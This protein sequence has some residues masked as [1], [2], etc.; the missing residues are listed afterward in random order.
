MRKTLM[1]ILDH[2]TAARSGRLP[3]LLCLL[4]CLAATR[5]AFAQTG[6]LAPIQQQFDAYRKQALQEKLYLH[7]DRPFY[8]CGETMWFKAYTLD[9]TLH[10]PLDLSKVAYVEVL[11]DTRKPV[12]QAKIALKDGAGNGSFVLPTTLASGNYTVRA[13]TSWMKNFDPEFYFQEPVTIVNS[14]TGLG[15]APEQAPTAYAIQFFP[16]GGNL[17]QGIPGKVAFQAVNKKSGK[18]ADFTGRIVDGEG[19][20]VAQLRPLKFGIGNFTFTPTAGTTYTAIIEFADKRVLRQQLPQV[21]AQGYSLRLRE[22]DPNQLQIMVSGPQTGTVYLLGHARQMVGVAESAALQQ[23]TAT[24]TVDT[25]KLPEGINH[26]TV[27]DSQRQPVC[28]RLYFKRPTQK[29]LVEATTDKKQYATRQQVT[30][31]LLTQASPGTAIPANLSVAVY[32]LDSLQ[33]ASPTDIYTYLWLTSDLKGTIEQPSYYFTASGPVADEAL[34]NLMLTHGWSRFRWEDVLQAQQPAYPFAPEYD[35]HFIRGKVTDA[36][37]GV[38]VRNVTAYLSA[39]GKH[40][41]LYSSASDA[42]GLVQFEMKDFYGPKEI[43]VQSDFQKDSSYTFE[44]LS[45]FSDRYAA[46][47]LP[48][49]GLDA[50]LRTALTQRHIGLQ[51]GYSYPISRNVF[52]VPAIDSTAFYGKTDAAYLL[53]D[54]T[55]FKVM[56]EVMREYVPGVQVRRRKGRFHFNVLDATHSSLFYTDPLVLLDGV[57]VFDIDKIMAFDPR[58]VRKLEVL[59][60]KYF[61]GPN[62][63]TGLVSYTTYQGDLAG[64]QLDPRA[65]LLEY[66]GL[67]LQREFYAPTYGTQEQHQSRLPD[68]RNLLYWS[69]DV[70]TGTDGKKTLS[71]YTSDEAGRYILV[72]QGLTK[73]GRAGSTTVSLEINHTL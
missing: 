37:T 64:F 11:D 4:L 52:R 24:F 58:K 70:R 65:L 33:A 6:A 66:E 59:T 69:P 31:S 12:L 2:L 63:Y 27:F 36:A 49:F 17:V 73:D 1:N 26:F 15:P 46:R 50:H 9:G 13:Y 3:V 61:L 7:L 5:P 39:P 60:R 29:L 19:M 35:G 22:L 47:A 40:V 28:E 10:Q 48:P 20:E 56:E 32:K 21:Y 23:S 71:F 67:Q 44:I 16:E 57:P 53:D 38:N 34:D 54:Y 72:V 55:R 51:V 45:P 25:R 8:A 68:L 14:F 42:N 30:A 43:V 41:R 62:M 18:G